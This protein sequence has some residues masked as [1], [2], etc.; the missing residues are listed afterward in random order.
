MNPIILTAGIVLLGIELVSAIYYEI[1]DDVAR[2]TC[3]ISW[4]TLTYLV[5]FT[6]NI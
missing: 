1:K 3:S 4:A 5:F 6:G 2:A